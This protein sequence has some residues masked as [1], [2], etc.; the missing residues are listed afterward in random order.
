MVRAEDILK[1][2]NIVLMFLTNFEIEV[3]QNMGNFLTP[4]N[5]NV[6]ASFIYTHNN[7]SNLTLIRPSY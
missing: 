6:G 7:G 5:L 4:S 1:V 2:N 3:K